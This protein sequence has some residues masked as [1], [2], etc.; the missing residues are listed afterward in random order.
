MGVLSGKPPGDGSG[1]EVS[2]AMA[3]CRNAPKR[4]DGLRSGGVARVAR[5]GPAVALL[6]Q[7]V[8]DE[9]GCKA[10]LM[11]VPHIAQSIA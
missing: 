9:A 2:T 10:T 5:Y 7:A 3:G 6:G 4:G 8:R 11:E 1:E